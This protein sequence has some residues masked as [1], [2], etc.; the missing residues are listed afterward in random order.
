MTSVMMTISAVIMTRVI[1]MMDGKRKPDGLTTRELSLSILIVVTTVN[2]V[3][4]V[5]MH[6]A[7]EG[8]AGV[9]AF[10]LSPL[11]VQR[12]IARTITL[13]KG[14]Q[15]MWIGGT[16]CHCSSSY[17]SKRLPEARGRPLHRRPLTEGSIIMPCLRRREQLGLLVE[18]M[19]MAKLPHS[20][21]TRLRHLSS[22]SV[23]TYMSMQSECGLRAGSAGHRSPRAG[24][25]VSPLLPLPQLQLLLHHLCRQLL[26]HHR[27][28]HSCLGSQAAAPTAS[29]STRS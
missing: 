15:L 14:Q 7:G 23:A 12:G 18:Q 17:G 6:A 20:Q 27:R 11:V 22:Q 13:A 28:C 26:P 9:A 1:T 3:N 8:T 2:M 21:L 5:R 29:W 16:A 24:I 4:M 19:L 25:V 10:L